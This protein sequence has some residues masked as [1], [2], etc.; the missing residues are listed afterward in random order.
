M[1]DQS[2]SDRTAD[3]LTLAQVQRWGVVHTLKDQSVAEHS[4][5]VAVIAMELADRLG[6]PRYQKLGSAHAGAPHDIWDRKDLLWWA[7][8][9]DA[10]EAITGDIN[11]KFKRDYPDVKSAVVAAEGRAMPWYYFERPVGNTSLIRLVK[12]ADYIETITFI[13]RW[14]IG[15]RCD[16]IYHELVKVLFVDATPALA[17]SINATELSV[18]TIVREVLHRSATEMNTA[19]LRRHRGSNV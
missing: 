13:K 14:G 17:K 6:L 2:L 10:P 16:D 19:Q 18:E 8:V 12:V 4:F 1:I 15:P 9:H 5:A 11:G 3:L 7:L